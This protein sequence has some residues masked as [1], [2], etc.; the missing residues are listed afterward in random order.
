M[1]EF[2]AEGPPGDP[3]GGGGGHP[4]RSPSWRLVSPTVATVPENEE[5][6][7][8]VVLSTQRRTTTTASGGGE[9]WEPMTD[10]TMTDLDEISNRSEIQFPKPILF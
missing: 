2:G 4:S 5:L 9:E 6:D 7:A 3:N 8:A 10:S 1:P